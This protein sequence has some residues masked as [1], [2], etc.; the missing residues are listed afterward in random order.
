[1]AS[2][3]A[4]EFDREM[5]ETLPLGDAPDEARPRT[6]HSIFDVIEMLLKD[7][8][9]LNRLL[10]EERYQRELTPRLLAVAVIGFA[11]YGVVAT[12]ILNGLAQKDFWL[13]IVPAAH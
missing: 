10:R 8:S 13:S 7:H 5:V 3:T 12:A 2:Y 1:M 9:L 4:V 11:I 6:S